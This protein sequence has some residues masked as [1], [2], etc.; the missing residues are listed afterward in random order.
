M[1][2]ILLPSLACI[3][4]FNSCVLTTAIDTVTQTPGFY[5]G[6]TRLSAEEKANVIAIKSK[7]N[8][9]Q[10]IDSITYAITAKHLLDL[11]KQ[12]TP[13]IIYLW[14]GRCSG[15]A[16]ISINAFKEHCIANKFNP[17]IV[18]EYFDYEMLSIQNQA[19]SEVYAINHWHYRTDYCNKYTKRFQ[20]DFVKILGGTFNAKY[21]YKYL[22]YDGKVLKGGHGVAQKLDNWD[23]LN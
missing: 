12:K 13:C 17:I 20:S 14:A 15:A 22:Y 7:D 6:Y 1:R 8:M 23:V 9:P 16:C 3:L 19:P 2:K 11:A 5:S 18:A 21:P 4:F 10:P